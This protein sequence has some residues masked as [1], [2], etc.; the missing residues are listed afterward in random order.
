MKRRNCNT[1]VKRILMCV[2]AAAAM[3]VSGCIPFPNQLPPGERLTSADAY[4]V[5]KLSDHPPQGRLE[6]VLAGEAAKN[7][8]N[9]PQGT[10]FT[11]NLERDDI[12]RKVRPGTYVLIYSA[13]KGYGAHGDVQLGSVVVQPGKINYIGSFCAALTQKGYAASATIYDVKATTDYQP[14]EVKEKLKSGYPELAHDID[15]SFVVQ[16]LR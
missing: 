8:F 3:T 4:V 2:I 11:L 9:R 10:S 12:I 13:Y 14:E 6:F 7:P 16:P 15:A 5:G 1:A